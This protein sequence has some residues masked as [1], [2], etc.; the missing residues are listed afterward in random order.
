METQQQA[1]TRAQTVEQEEEATEEVSD[2]ELGDINLVSRAP[3]P[4]MWTFFGSQSLNYTS[5]AFLVDS[6]ELDDFFWQGGVGVVFI[7]YATRNFTPRLK[8]DQNWFRYHDFGVLDFDSQNLQMDLNMISSGR[9]LVRER[10]LYVIPPFRA[11]GSTGEFTETLSEPKHHS[12]DS[13]SD[14]ADLP[15]DGWRRLLETWRPSSS[16]RVAGYLFGSATYSIRD[17]FS[18]R[19]HPAR[20]AA[21]PHDCPGRRAKISISP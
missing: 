8:F 7:P 15:R 4:K 2:P 18:C 16:D 10:F 20:R 21:L 17:D 6:G 14:R 5:N 1:R 13:A 9:Y 11:R 3:R 12:P 19:V